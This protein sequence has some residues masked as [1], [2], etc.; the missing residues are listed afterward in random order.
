MLRPRYETLVLD[1]KVFLRHEGRPIQRECQLNEIRNCYSPESFNPH[2]S[3]AWIHGPAGSGKT[4]C[5]RYLLENGI[6]PLGFL[7]IY[8]NCRERFTFLSVVEAMLQFVKP[9]RA[10]QRTREYQ[11]S[12]LRSSL[13][14]R[15][16]VIALDE[17]DVLKHQDVADL[18]HRLCS[19][20]N[21]SIVCIAPTQ[22][23]LQKLPETTR[24]R[25][26]PRR[27][28]FPRYSHGEIIAILLQIVEQGL[29]SGA[30]TREALDRI[31]DHSFGDARRAV[32]LL[33]NAICRA[34]EF[35]D[36]RLMVRHLEF[37]QPGYGQLSLED[38]LGIL[39]SHHR[40]LYNLV[41][42]NGPIP[43]PGIESEYRRLC[44]KNNLD[45][46]AT[47]TISKYLNTLCR[48]R[49][50]TREH[51][52]GTPGWIYRA[53]RTASRVSNQPAN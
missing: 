48:Q 3:H 10:A 17:I 1:E 43:G 49:V 21:A 23:L 11:L 22:N 34:E 5:V 46:I 53:A 50:L 47:R 37:S 44:E 27:V 14:K 4:Y 24:S 41:R 16:V 42:S 26:D 12:V 32:N 8:V 20:P 35:G 31:S 9:L 51:G 45:P 39:S 52:A 40:L 7:P 30:W 38:R 18:L 33:K 13:E 15:K 25:L 19:L 2:L 29:R 28:L 36:S 6:R